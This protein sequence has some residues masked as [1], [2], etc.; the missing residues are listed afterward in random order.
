MTITKK[1]AIL[2]CT[3]NGNKFLRQQLDSIF[4]QLYTNWVLYVSDDG[5]TDG[6]QD[7]LLEY[8]KIW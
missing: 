3:Y 6:T 4:N 8:Q 5:S 2:L 7:I 1:V